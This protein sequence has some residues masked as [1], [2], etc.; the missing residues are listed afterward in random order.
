MYC[1]SCGLESQLSDQFC[2]RCG[3]RLRPGE[4]SQ[5]TAATSA[6][7]PS[8]QRAISGSPIS[9]RAPAVKREVLMLAGAWPRYWARMFD[10]LLWCAVCGFLF[11]FFAPSFFT[12]LR[13][14]PGQ[15]NNQLLGLMLLPVAMFAD[16]LCYGVFANT[17]GKWLCGV[18]VE[19]LDAQRIPFTVYLRRNFGVY[20]SGLAMGIGLVALFTLLHN[21]NKVKA[22]RLT[23]WDENATVRANRAYG[24]ALR[25]TVTAVLYFAILFGL[26][27]VGVAYGTK[28]PEQELEEAAVLANKQGPKMV[29]EVTRLDS[30]SIAPGRVVQY[31]YTLVGVSGAEVERAAAN[32]EL[33][34]NVRHTV[35]SNFCKSPDMRFIRDRDGSVS[36]RYL[37][38]NGALI[39]TIKA[40]KS[41][42]DTS[43]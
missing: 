8:Q 9:V 1:P 13:G 11:G 24:G 42:C 19:A 7:D 30:I 32:I 40:S 20:F 12:A 39:G 3:A 4:Q 31:N 23:S 41:D 38:R 35:V 27:A 2:V 28:T 5:A 6:A 34:A 22:G 37:A 21:Y 43:M 33:E 14:L 29:D 26:V 36:Y 15:S 16:A 10:V 18:R 25:T 17:P